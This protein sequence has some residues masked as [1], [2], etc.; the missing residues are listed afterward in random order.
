MKICNETIF[1]VTQLM[2]L[3]QCQMILVYCFIEKTLHIKKEDN[4]MGKYFN[5]TTTKGF[6]RATTKVL[7]LY[8][9][10]HN[11]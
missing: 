4:H 6:E 10:R 1:D 3:L 7:T 2:H 9:F 5:P 11:V 8:L